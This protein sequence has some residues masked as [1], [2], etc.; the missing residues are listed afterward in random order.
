MVDFNVMMVGGAGAGK[1]SF[2][3]AMYNRFGDSTYKGF[4]IWLE[5]EHQRQMLSNLGN[6]VCNGVY[7]KNTST[8]SWY[9]FMLRFQGEDK[10]RF[11]WCDYRGGLLSSPLDRGTDE[12]LELARQIVNSDALIIF[13]D[14]TSMI[15]SDVEGYTTY[16]MQI[17]RLLQRVINSLSGRE[18]FPIAV[19]FTKYDSI[20]NFE[21]LQQSELYNVYYNTIAKQILNNNNI[22]GLQVC[23]KVGA[24]R[25]FWFGRTTKNIE[26]PFLHSLY[27]IIQRQKA[28]YEQS[29]TE[30]INEANSHRPS[31]LNSLYCFFTDEMSEAQKKRSKES[32][33][34]EFAR[35]AEQMN[36]PLSQI[37]SFVDSTTSSLS[38]NFQYKIN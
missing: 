36:E 17:S 20:P 1:T 12:M 26:Y 23:T 21:T 11:N 35:S 15:T 4:S 6:E 2:M 10:V 32:E 19:I 34:L 29:R 24:K 31:F 33:A 38:S 27:Y 9:R 13:L 18:D 25:R 8:R 14:S 3:G 28:L 37:R 22:K 16:I 7:P 30:K 5:N